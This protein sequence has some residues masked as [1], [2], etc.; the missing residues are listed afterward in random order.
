MGCGF[1]GSPVGE[2]KWHSRLAPGSSPTRSDKDPLGTVH[3]G[4][5][6][7]LSHR[8]CVLV[9]RFR[10]SHYPRCPRSEVWRR[11]RYSRTSERFRQREGESCVERC[12]YGRFG[13]FVF[14]HIAVY[15][16]RGFHDQV[17]G[18][19]HTVQTD[20]FRTFWCVFFLCLSLCLLSGC[21]CLCLCPVGTPS[22]ALCF[23][24]VGQEVRV[25]HILFPVHNLVCPCSSQWT[26]CW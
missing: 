21:F 23:L 16:I 8:G 5:L 24:C 15:G 1:L 9:S 12:W 6:Y 11:G 20:D 3:I 17:S 4:R 22:V 26:S 25:G 14:R 10:H 18:S 19:S 2:R 13:L 7:H